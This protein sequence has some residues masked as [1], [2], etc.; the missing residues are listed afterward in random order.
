MRKRGWPRAVLAFS[1]KFALCAS[2]WCGCAC[3]P[4]VVVGNWACPASTADGGA[5]PDADAPVT[6]PWSTG[7]E[8][9]FCDYT[10]SGGSCYT[11]G[12]ASY[13][14][15]RSP[16]R[17]GGS[18]AA[19][20]TVDREEDGG[21]IGQVRCGRQGILPKEAYYGAW[22]YIPATATNSQVWNLFHF[23]G[24]DSSTAPPPPEPGILDVSLVNGKNGALS[25][26]LHVFKNNLNQTAPIPIPIGSWFH[27]EAYLKRASDA[28]GEAALYQDGTRV[29]D[30]VNVIT[31]QNKWGLWYVGNYADA[32]SP[33]ESTVYVDD[34]TISA[35]L[36]KP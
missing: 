21:V 15:V 28:T 14:V 33:P 26:V 2:A 1:R 27:I 25:L 16:A 8:N 17:P 24:A 29:A 18:F 35:T 32:L 7:F 13:G 11:L 31:D 9:R 12:S 36:A 10:Q 6:I 5:I 19:A 34:V 3:Q 20:F 22:Y 23:L 30:F 4:S